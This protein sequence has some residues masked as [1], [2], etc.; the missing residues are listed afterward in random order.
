MQFEV[1]QRV[2]W[3]YRVRAGYGNVQRLPATIVKLGP[4]L[5]QIKVQKGNSEFVN[6]WVNRNRLEVLKD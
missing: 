5:V 6:R 4:R 2:V 1:G 3:L